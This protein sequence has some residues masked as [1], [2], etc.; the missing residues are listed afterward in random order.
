MIESIAN[1]LAAEIKRQVPEHPASQAVLRHS[2]AMVLNVGFIVI[3][4]FV[5]SLWTGY[6]K[7]V[8]LIMLSFALLRQVSGGIHLKSGISCVIVTTS[9]FTAL[10]FFH[11]DLLYLQMMN[12]I[13]LLLILRYAPSR[14]EKQSRIPKHH[15]P[16]LKAIAAAF[17]LVN[18]FLQSPIIAVTFLVQS[19]TLI[20]RKEVKF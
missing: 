18:F 17:V 16:K 10:S 15:Y 9:L 8:G 19:L 1:R 2:L 5:L 3:F 14:I 13:S 11:A 7:E 4:S 20:Y 6:T 12:T